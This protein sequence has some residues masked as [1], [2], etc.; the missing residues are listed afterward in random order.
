MAPYDHSDHRLSFARPTGITKRNLCKAELRSRDI[1][2]DM[3][4]E[5]LNDVVQRDLQDELK[6]SWSF[7]RDHHS[8]MLPRSLTP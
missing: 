5:V 6:V 7:D 3:G 1:A 4:L 2:K 8:Y